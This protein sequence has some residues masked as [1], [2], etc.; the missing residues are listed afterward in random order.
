MRKKNLLLVSLLCAMASR[1]AYS[2]DG[3]ATKEY[4]DSQVVSV[5]GHVNTKDNTLYSRDN[6]L[7]DRLNTLNGRLVLV[8]DM[9]NAQDNTGRWIELETNQKLAIPAINELYHGLQGK[10]PVINEQN[11]LPAENISGL[12]TVATTGSFNDLVDAP[13]IPSIDGLATSQELLDL[14]EDLLAEI[15]KK[16]ASGDYLTA[17]SLQSIN[18]A[19][20]ALQSNKADVSALTDLQNAIDGF[21]AKLDAKEDAANKVSTITEEELA[22]MTTE[23]KAKKFP[24]IAVA[25]TIADTAVTK[26]NSVAGDLSKLQ[27]QVG[28]NTA[29]IAAIKGAGYQDAEAVQGA[30]TTATA[31]FVT[32]SE[33]GGYAKTDELGVLAT[34]DSVAADQIQPDAV[35]LE[36]IAGR[37]P[38]PG[39]TLLM[40]VDAEGNV[41]WLSVEILK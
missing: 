34:K 15:A 25:Q 35:T 16:Q 1:A 31:D 29:D 6:Q 2:E 32:E 26:V 10:H 36:K 5:V 41:T 40:S 33:L 21:L 23:D 22:E 7:A 3:Y 38:K 13:E 12:A 28:T 27:T 20:N 4:V 14:Q 18:Q 30:I 37:M 17:E 9:L 19:I 39:E 8:R 11:K 24:S